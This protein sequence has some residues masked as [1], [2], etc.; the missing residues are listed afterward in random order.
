[1][2]YGITLV[3]AKGVGKIAIGKVKVVAI[4]LDITSFGVRLPVFP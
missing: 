3:Y 1:V 4:C 2:H